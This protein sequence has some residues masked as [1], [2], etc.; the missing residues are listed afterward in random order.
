VGRGGPALPRRAVN[1]FLRR[2]LAIEAAAEC[3]LAEVPDW[4]WDGESLPV[5][6]EDIADSHYGLLVRAQDEL[7][8]LA[9]LPREVHISGLLFPAQRE[10]WVDAEEAERAPGRRRFT[11]SHELG[12]WVLHCAVGAEDD[13]PVH[14][15]SETMREQG[16]TLEKDEG[17]KQ[18]GRVRY[19]PTEREANQFAAALLMPRGLVEK[20]HAWLDGVVRRLARTCRVSVEAMEWRLRF[21]KETGAHLEQSSDSPGPAS[22]SG[23]E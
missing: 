8:A 16:T 3:E 13:D 7:A 19:P 20:E 9:G 15:R 18:A 5:P 23:N 1:D 4:L 22:S 6:V 21:L 10:I 2:T 17:P 11:I 14:C 12:H